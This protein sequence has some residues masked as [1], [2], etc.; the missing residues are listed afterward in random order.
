MNTL[1]QHLR[2]RLRRLQLNRGFTATFIVT[3]ALAIAV[4]TAAFAIVNALLLRSLPY[5][6]PERIGAIDTRVEGSHPWDERYYLDGE[7]CELL[8]DNVPSLVPA[9]S[10]M[11]PSGVNLKAGTCC[12]VVAL[13]AAMVPVQRGRQGRSQGRAAL[14]MTKQKTILWRKNDS[15]KKSGTQLQNSGRAIFRASAREPGDSPR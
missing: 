13:A 3:L 1:V 6:H 7:Q 15:T 14:P 5:R 9:I 11:R 4:I 8:R 2:Y 10:G 12:S